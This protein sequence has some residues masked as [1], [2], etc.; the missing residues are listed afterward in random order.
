MIRLSA[1]DIGA[2]GYDTSTGFG[3]ARPRARRC[4]RSRPS[5]IRKEPNEDIP[6]VNGRAFKT[7]DRPIWKGKGNDLAERAAGRLRGPGRRLPPARAR[8]PTALSSPSSR[9]SATRT[10]SSTRRRRTHVEQ[11]NH[12]AAR[13]RH[14]GTRTDT[15]RYRNPGTRTRT[16]YV[17]V[18]IDTR[19]RTL[20]AGYT[21]TAKR[22]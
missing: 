17:R 19:Q 15:V 20:D 1:K 18:F 22:G 6:F 8:A 10:S 13:S 11:A 21:L 16:A 12:R 3:A 4:S 14:T 5:R 7:A 9:A 2:K